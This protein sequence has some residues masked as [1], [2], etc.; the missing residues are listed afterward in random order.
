[1]EGT[2]VRPAAVAGMFYPEAPAALR[3]DVSARLAAVAV[4]APAP[5]A[6]VV[7]HAGYVYSGGVAATAYASVRLAAGTLRHVVLIGPSHR[8]GFRGIA[9][10]EADAFASPAGI[11]SIDA[12]SRQRALAH[13]AVF[14]SDRAHAQEHSLEVQLPFLSAV[15]EHFELLPLL[16]GEVSSKDVADVLDRVWGGRDTLIVVSTDL[17]HFHDQRTA[18]RLDDATAARV[19]AFDGTLEGDDACGAAGLNGFLVAA[20]RRGMRSRQLDICTSADTAGDPRRVVGYGAFAFYD[21]DY[22]HDAVD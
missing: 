16:T 9:V 1:M 3:R 11:V 19:L 8:V 4:P 14:A 10:P 2:H 22:D 6:I 13:P 21:H 20:A 18:R 12:E 15:L 7:P 17:S 5:K